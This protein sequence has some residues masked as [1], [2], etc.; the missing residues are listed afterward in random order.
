MGE[1]VPIILMLMA[2]VAALGAKALVIAAREH[3]RRFH[4][5]WFAQLS[6]GGSG[7]R[8]G[9]PDERARRKLAGPLITGRMPPGPAQDA[10]LVDLARK[11]RLALAALSL[12]VLAVALIVWLR[13]GGA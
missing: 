13:A 6:S 8:L 12:C 1:I 4:P 2:L 7:I 5:D 9:G 3:V 11:L 10:A